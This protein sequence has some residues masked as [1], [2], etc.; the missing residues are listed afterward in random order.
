MKHS[1]LHCKFLLAAFHITK[2]CVGPVQLDDEV[3]DDPEIILW[4]QPALFVSSPL[5]WCAGRQGEPIGGSDLNTN[6]D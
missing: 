2:Q 6:S 5:G 3:V 1:S 4:D